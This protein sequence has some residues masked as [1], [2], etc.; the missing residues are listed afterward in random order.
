VV[1]AVADGMLKEIEE[2]RKL[3]VPVSVSVPVK[4]KIDGQIDIGNQ[5]P[6]SRN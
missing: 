5:S 3:P 4:T 6:K 2:L 1:R